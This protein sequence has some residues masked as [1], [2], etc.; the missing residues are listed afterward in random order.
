MSALLLAAAGLFL[1]FIDLHVVQSEIYHRIS[2]AVLFC[3]FV[4]ENGFVNLLYTAHWSF[5]SSVQSENEGAV[6]FAPIAGLGSI[7][8]TLTGLSVSPLVKLVGLP[9]LLLIASVFL[10]GTELCS[11]AAYRIAEEVSKALNDS[12]RQRDICLPTHSLLFART[13]SYRKKRK[14]TGRSILDSHCGSELEVCSIECQY[15]ER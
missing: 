6:W 8:S 15:L 11:D 1:N 7:A 12:D 14:R 10:V 9:G 4:M 5:L 3:L 13:V 2:K